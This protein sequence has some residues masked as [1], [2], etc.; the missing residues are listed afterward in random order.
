MCSFPIQL[1][2]ICKK[3]GEPM[4]LLTPGFR[5][6]SMRIHEDHERILEELDELD[7]ALQH[8]VCYSG[9]V[10]DA[11][12]RERARLLAQRLTAELPE[13]CVREEMCVLDKVASVSPEL[14]EFVEQMKA[15]HSELMAELISFCQLLADLDDSIDLN[16]AVE[17]LRTQGHQL[18][19]SWRAHMT[20]EESQLSGFLC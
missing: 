10:V 11:G 8:L 18:T 7:A 4:A 2:W 16:T 9:K 17:S 3:R 12:A 19:N 14:R 1:D 20:L 15:Q 5:I 6:D 13:H